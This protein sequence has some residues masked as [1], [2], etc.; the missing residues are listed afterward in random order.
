MIFTELLVTLG[1]LKTTGMACATCAHNSKCVALRVIL[2]CLTLALRAFDCYTHWRVWLTIRDSGLEHPLLSIP[3]QWTKAWFAFTCIGTTSAGLYIVN[4]ISGVI[5]F[6]REYRKKRVT[7]LCVPCSAVGFNYVTRVEI[8][9]LVNISLEDLPL[10]TLSLV[11][12]AA[13]YSC[14]SPTPSD[15]RSLLN[16]VFYS[17]LASLLQVVWCLTRFLFHL[18][19]RACNR[20]KMRSKP[21]RS[22]SRSGSKNEKEPEEGEEMKRKMKEKELELEETDSKVRRRQLYPTK[23][24]RMKCCVVFHS[25]ALLVVCGLTICI[26]VT[27]IT[28]TKHEGVLSETF[29]DPDQQLSIYQ[30]HPQQR[31]LLNVSNVIDSKNAGVCL[32]EVFH[33][34][35]NGSNDTTLCDII[36]RY[37]NGRI[38]FNYIEVIAENGSNSSTI[39]QESMERCSEYYT[40]LFLGHITEDGVK[41]FEDSCV[42][43]LVLPN[44][45]ALL[46]RKEYLPVDCDTPLPMT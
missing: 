21:S 37:K 31:L 7:D 22:S 26:S 6:Y 32:R 4:E 42:G 1:Y 15:N 2:F 30:T 20:C 43:T 34:P 12:A 29:F 16:A 27:A 44:N 11:F 45:N 8:L 38:H 14:N 36:F 17:S 25:V 13:Q 41:R 28:L 19:V 24:C 10:L 9:S 33:L 23:C 3:T 5:A 39:M 40:G 35:T 46:E 18:L